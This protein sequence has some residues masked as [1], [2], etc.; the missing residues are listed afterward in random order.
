MSTF[1]LHLLASN[2]LGCIKYTH[3]SWEDVTARERTD[4]QNSYAE[5]NTI[6]WRMC[7]SQVT[8]VCVIWQL[9]LHVESS[10]VWLMIMSCDQMRCRSRFLRNRDRD[11]NIDSYPALRYPEIYV[12][13]G[14]YKA[15]YESFPHLCEPQGY[16]P[17]LHQDH[18]M[19]LKQFRSK[20]SSWATADKGGRVVGRKTV[21]HRPSLNLWGV[22]A[23][24]FIHSIRSVPRLSLPTAMRWD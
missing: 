8:V 22:A 12:L 21:A 1:S 13:E 5:S 10:L 7:L 6:N 9:R 3:S 18:L 11:T 19:E 20:S 24:I 14:G 2:H 17:M 15:F 16:V 4:H 23:Q